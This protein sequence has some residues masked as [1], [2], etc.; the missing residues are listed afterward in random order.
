MDEPGGWIVAVLFLAA[1]AGLALVGV[2]VVVTLVSA[3]L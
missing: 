2:V 1:L 3:A